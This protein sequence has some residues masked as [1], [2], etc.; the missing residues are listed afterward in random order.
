[1]RATLWYLL[2]FCILV[3]YRNTVQYV[4]SG[5]NDRQEDL[6]NSTVISVSLDSQTCYQRDAPWKLKS[7]LTFLLQNAKNRLLGQ[8]EIMIQVL[9]L[10]APTSNTNNFSSTFHEHML[11]TLHHLLLPGSPTQYLS[12]RKSIYTCTSLRIVLN[13]GL[14]RRLVSSSSCVD[15]DS[16]VSS[17]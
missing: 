15:L 11:V 12:L 13:F 2:F 6:L 9:S 5:E 10:H 4:A 3:V 8:T 17:P 1:L 7:N 14:V 16:S